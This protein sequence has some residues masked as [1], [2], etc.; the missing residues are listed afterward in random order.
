M[1]EAVRAIWP[2]GAD[3]IVDTTGNHKVVEKAYDAMKVKGK[4]VMLGWV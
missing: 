3:I 2:E 1:I 4:I